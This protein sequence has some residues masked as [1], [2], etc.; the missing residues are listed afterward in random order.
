MPDAHEDR[1]EMSEDK[2]AAATTSSH[3]SKSPCGQARKGVDHA[4][5]IRIPNPATAGRRLR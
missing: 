2:G 4:S 3:S 5:K 1:R